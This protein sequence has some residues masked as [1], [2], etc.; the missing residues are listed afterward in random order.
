MPTP[1]WKLTKRKTPERDGRACA[2]ISLRR[3]LAGSGQ[4]GRF[5]V[6]SMVLDYRRDCAAPAARFFVL[7]LFFCLSPA[8]WLSV[9]ANWPP[10]SFSPCRKRKRSPAAKRKRALSIVG[11]KDP[12]NRAFCEPQVHTGHRL[13]A[14]APFRTLSRL[15]CQFVQSGGVTVSDLKSVGFVLQRTASNR[16]RLFRAPGTA[17]IS[18]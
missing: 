16:Q 2:P 5:L 11:T 1:Q 13:K 12:F 10:F 15:L 3:F 7:T 17:R 8:C 9:Q 4:P 6:F 14:Y 18:G